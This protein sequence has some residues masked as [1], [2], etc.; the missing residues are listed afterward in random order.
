[1]IKILSIGTEYDQYGHM[2]ALK[3]RIR[4]DSDRS[5]RLLLIAS[6]TSKERGKPSETKGEFSSKERLTIQPGEEREVIMPLS[7]AILIPKEGE[8]TLGI[9]SVIEIEQAREAPSTEES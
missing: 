1:M 4:N 7:P 6:V 3:I 8:L 2:V 5:Y 9:G